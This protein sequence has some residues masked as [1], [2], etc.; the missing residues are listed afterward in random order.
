MSPAVNHIPI[1]CEHKYVFV[2]QIEERDGGFR[3]ESKFYDTFFCEKC[4]KTAR[5]QV[6]HTVSYGDG[7]RETRH[8][9]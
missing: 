4:L 8:D 3:P 9:V 1:P 5:V 7:R 6:A 2:R